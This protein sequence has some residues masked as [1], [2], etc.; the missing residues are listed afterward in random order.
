MN[1]KKLFA[2]IKLPFQFLH[3]YSGI[4]SGYVNYKTKNGNFDEI[5]CIHPDI[6]FIK[7]KNCIYTCSCPNRH[8]RYLKVIH[9]YY[10]YLILPFRQQYLIY[11][12]GVSLSVV[13]RMNSSFSSTL[14]DPLI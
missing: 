4:N 11:L 7:A 1:K 6:D 3:F 10:T 5:K 8:R 2:V 13:Y 14:Y 12:L 9:R